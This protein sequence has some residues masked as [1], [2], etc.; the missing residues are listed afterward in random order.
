MEHPGQAFLAELEAH[1]MT[2]VVTQ[3]QTVVHSCVACLGSV[4]NKITKNYPLIR[5]CF[6][7]WVTIKLN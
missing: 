4:I 5:E 7:K 3:R 2:L 1:L 6:A